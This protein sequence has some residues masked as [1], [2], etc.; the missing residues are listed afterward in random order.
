ML[1]SIKNQYQAINVYIY[2]YINIVDKIN[3]LLYKIKEE[4]KIL[5]CYSNGY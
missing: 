4:S 3:I 1:G 5:W 2:I